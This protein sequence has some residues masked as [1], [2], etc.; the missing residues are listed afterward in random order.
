MG[1]GGNK[2]HVG[3]KL[4]GTRIEQDKDYE[5]ARDPDIRG[6]GKGRREAGDYRDS[7]DEQRR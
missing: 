4:R 7:R 5:V 6:A 2:D 3:Q 1:K